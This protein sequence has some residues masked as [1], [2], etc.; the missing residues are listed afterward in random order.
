MRKE[1]ERMTESASTLMSGLAEQLEALNRDT[2]D[3][4][5]MKDTS[6]IKDISNTSDTSDALKKKKKW[7]AF[8]MRFTEAEYKWLSDKAWENR[9]ETAPYLRKLIDEMMEKDGDEN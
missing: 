6:D 9:M 7:V 1:K 5:G 4:K 8:P 3:M 2:S